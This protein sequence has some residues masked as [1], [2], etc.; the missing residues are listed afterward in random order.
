MKI[1]VKKQVNNGYWTYKL[2]YK[3][4]GR[5]L[6]RFFKN[7][8]DA[9]ACAFQWR[10]A[11]HYKSVRVYQRPIRVAGVK[12]QVYCVVRTSVNTHNTSEETRIGS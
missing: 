8:E 5:R 4:A 6:R 1:Q 3:L 10:Q 11:G 7:R 2:D 12:L 9:E